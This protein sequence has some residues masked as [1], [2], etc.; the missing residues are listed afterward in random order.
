MD[1]FLKGKVAII[2]GASQ[3]LSRAIAKTLAQE[4]VRVFA[5]ARNAELLNESHNSLSMKGSLSQ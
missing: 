1:L 2:T 3:G 4:G 5:T